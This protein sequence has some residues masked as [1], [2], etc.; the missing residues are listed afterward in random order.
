MSDPIKLSE[1]VAA[2]AG[3]P[4]H[5]DGVIGVIRH[6]LRHEIADGIVATHDAADV[7]IEIAQAALEAIGW[8]DSQSSDSRE[9]ALRPLR[10][11]LDKVQP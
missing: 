3:I 6:S 11:A 1:L 7:L 4:A 5:D 8:I 2:R 10:D 9:R